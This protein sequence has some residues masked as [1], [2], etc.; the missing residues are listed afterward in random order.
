MKKFLNNMVLTAALVMAVAFILAGCGVSTDEYGNKST[1]DT[2]YYYRI[3][4]T[5]MIYVKDTKVIYYQYFYSHKG[6]MAP[7]YNEYGQLCR[8]I[9]GQIVPIE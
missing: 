9:D 5:P 1:E 6:Y 8:Y 2:K 3:G 7:Y 4:D